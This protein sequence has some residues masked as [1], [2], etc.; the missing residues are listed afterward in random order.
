M[1]LPPIF[2]P[3]LVPPW[4]PSLRSTGATLPR[5]CTNVGKAPSGETV[6]MVFDVE[7]EPVI[8]VDSPEVLKKGVY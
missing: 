8:P 6:G 7:L 3:Y 1:Q 4:R 5:W 2:C